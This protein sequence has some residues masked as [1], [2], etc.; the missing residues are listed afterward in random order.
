MPLMSKRYKCNFPPIDPPAHTGGFFLSLTVVH[1]Y[2]NP[3]PTL[4]PIFFGTL[5][6]Q[7]AP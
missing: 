3:F 4:Q 1:N 5:Q 2:S 6:A 7:E